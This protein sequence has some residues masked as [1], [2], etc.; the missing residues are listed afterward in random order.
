M[1]H[2]ADKAIIIGI[3]SLLLSLVDKF[4]QA[5]RLPHFQRLIERGASMLAWP[6]MPTFTPPNWTT[7]ATGTDPRVHGIQGWQFMTTDCRAEHLWTSAARAAKR[8]ITLRYPCSYPP[9]AE[10]NIAVEAG[11]PNSTP[12]QIAPC[13]AY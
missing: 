5:G 8:S 1:S 12:W 11:L 10:G 6:S 3:D 4:R 9:T 2:R 13:T 7:I